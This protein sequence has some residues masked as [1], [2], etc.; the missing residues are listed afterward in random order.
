VPVHVTFAAL[1]RDDARR[2]LGGMERVDSADYARLGRFLAET[3]ELPLE[4]EPFSR[5]FLAA[6]RRLVPCDFVGYGECDWIRHH[7]FCWVEDPIYDGPEPEA[8]D[9]GDDDPVGRF[10]RESH[11]FRAYRLSD[12]VSASELNRS[13]FYAEWYGFLGVTHQ[14]RVRLPA[15]QWHAKTFS[16]DRGPGADFTVRDRAVLDAVQPHLAGRRTLWQAARLAPPGAIEQAGLTARERE[17]VGLL[18]EGLTN[19]EIAH[20]LW[21]AP[22]TVRRHLENIYEKLGVHTRTAAALAAGRLL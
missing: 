6:L 12:V 17:V 8:Q 19:A 13:R 1:S 11:D 9:F 5:A 20:R 2:I 16:F 22:G 4:D 10:V 15:P 3:A 18:A 14:L 21:I 7:R